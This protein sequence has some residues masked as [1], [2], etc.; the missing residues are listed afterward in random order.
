MSNRRTL[1]HPAGGGAGPFQLWC[2]F[3]HARRAEA[4]GQRP[5]TQSAC[6]RRPHPSLGRAPAG[7]RA[8]GRPRTPEEDGG[9]CQHPSRRQPPAPRLADPR[10]LDRERGTDGGRGRVLA[11]NRHRRFLRRHAR[12]GAARRA[13]RVPDRF[14]SGLRHPAGS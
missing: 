2:H 6:G 5:L 8:G 11:G 9:A 14:M 10:A 4:A 7:E 3:G 12:D 1:Q 13:G